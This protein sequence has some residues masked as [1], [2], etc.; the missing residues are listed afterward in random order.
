MSIDID[1]TFITLL[2]SC[3]AWIRA[4]L[5]EFEKLVDTNKSDAN[6]LNK[7]RSV[8]TVAWKI[9]VFRIHRFW[10]TVLSWN[11]GLIKVLFTQSLIVRHYAGLMKKVI[12]PSES[13]LH[14]GCL[15]DQE[16]NRNLFIFYISSINN[17]SFFTQKVMRKWLIFVLSGSRM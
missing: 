16:S 9:F 4:A 3:L 7:R 13:W 5:L 8:V 12:S 6:C 2:D 14:T 15:F 1:V 11:H 10:S 17:L